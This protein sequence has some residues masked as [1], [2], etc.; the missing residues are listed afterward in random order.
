MR[1]FNNQKKK[2]SMTIALVLIVFVGLAYAFLNEKLIDVKWNNDIENKYSTNIMVYT[3]STKDLLLSVASKTQNS[4][5]VIKSINT[6]KN[7]GAHNFDIKL[8]VPNLSALNKIIDKV[9]PQVSTNLTMT[10]ILKYAKDVAK[11]KIV[12]QTRETAFEDGRQKSDIERIKWM[13]K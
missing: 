3:N 1:R 4:G 7:D 2:L 11:Y 8:S 12:E 5:V 9:F 6:I 10:E 13:K